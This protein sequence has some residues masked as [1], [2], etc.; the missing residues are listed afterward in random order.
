M[1]KFVKNQTSINLEKNFTSIEEKE[2]SIDVDTPEGRFYMGYSDAA[3]AEWDEPMYGQ[4][5]DDPDYQAGYNACKELEQKHIQ[6]EKTMEIYYKK[7][8]EWLRRKKKWVM[9]NVLW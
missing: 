7:K 3:Y 4:Y 6:H 8:A 1:N 9:G 5:K 2:I